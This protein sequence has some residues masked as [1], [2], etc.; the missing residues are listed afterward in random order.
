MQPNINLPLDARAN[1]ILFPRPPSVRARLPMLSKL[2]LIPLLSFAVAQTS[3]SCNPL[4]QSGCSADTALGKEAYFSFQE[5]SSMFNATADSDLI[6]YG[7]D[8]VSFTLAEQGD[9]PTIQSNFYIMFGRVEFMAKAANG[10]GIVSSF[11][12]ESDDLDE[13]DLEWLGGDTSQVASNY[14][15]KGD[16]SSYDRAESHSVSNPQDTWHNYT[17]DWSVNQTNFYVDGSVVRTLSSDNADGYPQTPM[18]IRIGIWA[19]GDPSNSEGTIEWAGGETDY[20]D[21]PFVFYVKD[22]YVQDYSTGSKYKYGD[23]SGDWSS[24]EAVDGKING[25]TDGSAGTTTAAGGPISTFSS[26]S[27]SSGSAAASKATSTGGSATASGS[28]S[29]SET[30]AGSQAIVSA[31]GVGGAS[32]SASGVSASASA[33][34]DSQSSS[35]SSS[36]ASANSTLDQTNDAAVASMSSLMSGLLVLVPLFF[37][38]NAV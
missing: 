1:C 14:F 7:S 12:L 34:A 37:I 21:A 23:T 9:A 15:S 20:S 35:S 16:T 6:D 26:D 2:A 18:N 32:A 4:K 22:L 29:G 31:A 24:I 5:K 19:G 11:V 28:G 10:T 38:C 13:I 3:S 36:S 27:S 17:V 33:G 25:N 8:G 30:A